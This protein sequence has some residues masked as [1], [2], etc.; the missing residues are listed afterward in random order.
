MFDL[1]FR[2]EGVLMVFDWLKKKSVRFTYRKEIKAGLFFPPPSDRELR[3][4]GDRVR[5]FRDVA[6][7]FES[8]GAKDDWVSWHQSQGWVVLQCEKEAHPKLDDPADQ[9]AV[10]AGA[11]VYN[12]FMVFH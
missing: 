11:M 9:A 2:G 8:H 10:D 1:W 3:Q 5:P 6:I 12:V 4:G 7:I